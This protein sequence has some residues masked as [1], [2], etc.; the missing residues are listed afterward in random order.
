MKAIKLEKVIEGVY[1]VSIDGVNHT[2]SK[3][4]TFWRVNGS[5]F[6]RTRSEAIE[7]I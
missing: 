6:F 3:Y 5:G 2:V 7:S 1:N 4:K